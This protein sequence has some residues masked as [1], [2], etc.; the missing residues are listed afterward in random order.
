MAFLETVGELFGFSDSKG[1][2]LVG[3]DKG[4]SQLEFKGQ[5]IAENMSE[6]LGSALGETT[7]VNKDKPNQQWLHGNSEQFIFTSRLFA[8]DSFKNIKQQVET[9]KSFTKRNKKLKRAPIFLFTAGTEIGFTC[10]VKNVGITYD[11]LKVDGSLQGIIANITLQKLEEIITGDASTSLASQIKFAAGIV[12]GAA[13]IASQLGRVVDI[14]GFS[15][16]TIDRVVKVIDGDTFE[17]IAAAEY[18]DA[19]LGDILRRVQPNKVNL[20]SGDTVQLIEPTEVSEIPVTQQSVSL[21]NTLE[22][23]TLREEFFELRNR[24]TTIFV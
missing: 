6:G 11:E 1:W 23:L 14:P 16:H 21:K 24:K 4:V 17:S 2:S 8:S 10:F 3:Q 9:L 19:L 12:A 15:L 7:T 5:F 13:G 18:G 22:N 20:V